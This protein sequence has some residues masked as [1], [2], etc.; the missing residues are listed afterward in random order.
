MEL[1]GLSVPVINWEASNLPEQWIKFQRHVE[2]MFTGPLKNKTKKE[3]ISYLLIWVGDKGRDIHATWEPFTGDDA[4]NLQSYYD[5]FKAHVQPS[6]NPIF[7]R[8]KFNNEVQGTDSIDAFITRLRLS[9]ADCSFKD[10]DEMIRDRIVFGTNSGKVREKLINKGEGLT[11]ENAIQIAQA[12]EYA[13]KQ[14]QSMASANDVHLVK[15]HKSKHKGY[16]NQPFQQPKQQQQ[17]QHR[18]YH[19]IQKQDGRKP[20]KCQRC[21]QNTHRPGSKCPAEHSTCYACGM[22]NHFASVCRSRNKNVDN[23][24]YSEYNYS[25]NV[26]SENQ[27]YYVDMIDTGSAVD[28]LP[29]SHYEKLKI[30]RPLEIAENRLTSY[31]GNM[32][33]VCGI[34]NLQLRY[35]NK[36]S[37]SLCYVVDSPTVP[38]LSLQS[39]V[40]LGLIKLTY[41][42]D[43]SNTEL[44]KQR[45]MSEYGNLFQGVGVIPGECK[46]H[47]K[48]DAVPVINAPR[49]VPEALRDR[50]HEELQRMEN[51]GIITKVTEP[52]DWV[53]SLVIVEKPKTGKLRVCLDPKALNEAIRR[54]HYPMR[55]IDDVTSRLTDAKYFSILDITHAYWSI[56]LDEQSSLLTTFST[57]FGRYRW[58]RLPYGISASSDIFMQKVDEIFEGLQ[59]L[60]AIVDDILIYGKTREE[61]DANLRN[62]LERA[63][64]KRV[65]FNPDKCIIG[66]NEVPFFGHLITSTGLK[67]DPSK[68]EAIMNLKIPENRQQ[69]ENVLGMANYLQKFSPNLAEVTSPMRSLL[70]KDVEFVWDFSQT[71]GI[72]EN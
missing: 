60:T 1:T 54:P 55:T 4:E 12:H 19:N 56:K 7:A 63:H 48:S 15:Q 36:T 41:S 58:L 42:I 38:L 13:Q 37:E 44:D 59:G 5:K 3:K 18:N 23:V 29:L 31:T 70:K 26:Q 25:D 39:S 61:H 11:L 40:N 28:I 47:I 20:L 24:K 17:Q 2:L 22:Q 10:K 27:D 16:K 6:L 21:G 32:L 49:R 52:T 45:V 69:L 43:R 72:Y 67:P 62:A 14:L 51:D 71:E 53:N 35:N 46:L 64:S 66:V 68:I 9:A 30:K 57:V 33:P 8:Y 34:I 65:K 50:L